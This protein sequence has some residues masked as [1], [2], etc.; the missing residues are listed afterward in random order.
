L[1]LANGMVESTAF[2]SRLQPTSIQAGTQFSLGFTYEDVGKKNNN[3]NVLT[4]TI[5]QVGSVTQTY[6]Y[7]GVN[8]LLSAAENGGW[9]QTY[10]HDPFGNHWVKQNSGIVL[11]ALTP[12]ASTF[13]DQ[14]T[15]RIVGQ[16][17]NNR[18]LHSKT[19]LQSARDVVF[20]TA[21][22]GA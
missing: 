9:S 1:N 6:G 8:R 22:A 14:A 21:F 10:D 11:S 7:D 16:C 3:G 15:N 4:Q 12:T 2:N 20:S 19:A 18:G 5:Q 17:R 13:F